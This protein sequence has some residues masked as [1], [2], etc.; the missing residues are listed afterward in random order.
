M[1]GLVK[2]S[3]IIN[4]VRLI[5]IIVTASALICIF[6]ANAAM[7]QEVTPWS[8]SVYLPVY[9][10]ADF[11][12]IPG[13]VGV[14]RTLT[15]LSYTKASQGVWT[16][17]AV[18]M[19]SRYIF[20]GGAPTTPSDA[21]DFS[22]GA[23]Y[24]KPG[25]LWSWFLTANVHDSV[26]DNASF[27][28][29]GYTEFGG[30]LIRAVNQKLIIGLSAVG[31]T[32]IEKDNAYG[33]A[34]YIEYDINEHSRI[35]TVRSTDPSIG[36]TYIFDNNY[37]LYFIAHSGQS[38]FRIDKNLAVI[39]LETGFRIGATYHNQSGLTLEGFVG[40]VSRTVEYDQSGAELVDTSIDATTFAG[41]GVST[42][43]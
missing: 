24:F 28:D 20:G 10:K 31:R 12:D 25:T 7:A 3:N 15:N 33:L 27:G 40:T 26:A 8:M 37:E 41:I 19:Q 21:R 29:G 4:R 35:G 2:I 5:H 39:D 43:F 14:S 18:I 11:K 17:S 13:H 6:V 42:K 23:T 32:E 38:Q 36:Y 34:P 1:S 9:Q 30:G 16:Y 22:I